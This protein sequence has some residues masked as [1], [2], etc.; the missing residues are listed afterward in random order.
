[1]AF[2]KQTVIARPMARSERVLVEAVG[3][4]TVIYDLDTNVAHALKPLAAAVFNYADGT[5]T[6]SEIAE[7]ASY[8]LATTVT[9]AEV[10]DAISQLDTLSLLD[11][12]ELSLSEAGL[13]RRDALKVFGAVGAGTVLVSSVAAPFASAAIVNISAN[14]D[15]RTCGSGAGAMTGSATTDGGWPQ[16]Y[17]GSNWG[18]V[19]GTSAGAPVTANDYKLGHPCYVT[20]GS[21]GT[22]GTYQVVPCDGPTYQCAEVVCVPASEGTITGAYGASGTPEYG[23][24]IL[25]ASP[26]AGNTANIGYGPYTNNCYSGYEYKFCCGTGTSACGSTSPSTCHSS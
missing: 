7:L 1:M 18:L 16:P 5:N 20:S 17:S 12:P 25:T 21:S 24:S 15:N 11:I 26:I 13:S 6:A 14:G 9:E 8:R 22:K 2:R 10:A 4:E 23:D 19:S 3:D